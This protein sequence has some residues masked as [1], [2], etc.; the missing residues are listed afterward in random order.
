MF[1]VYS[2]FLLIALPTAWPVIQQEPHA[3][4]D[5][6]GGDGPSQPHHPQ[7]R[8]S[9]R[10]A[11]PARRDQEAGGG[12]HAAEQAVHSHDISAA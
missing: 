8:P 5:P 4:T 1:N 9:T 7:I 10:S 6:Y 11:T 3:N 12:R 2:V